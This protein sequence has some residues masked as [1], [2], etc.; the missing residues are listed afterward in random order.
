[1]EKTMNKKK[2]GEDD[3]LSETETSEVRARPAKYHHCVA[4]GVYAGKERMS[5]LI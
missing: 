4:D 1:M 2:E 3:H 5:R